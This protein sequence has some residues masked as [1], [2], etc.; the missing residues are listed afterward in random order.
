MNMVIGG[1]GYSCMIENYSEE[2]VDVDDAGV[3]VVFVFVVADLRL[4]TVSST[5]IRSSMKSNASIWILP[6]ATW[7]VDDDALL[8]EAFPVPVPVPDW[9][10]RRTG[11]LVVAGVVWWWKEK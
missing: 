5:S 1:G 8:L 2:D 6:F 4:R 7:V 9:A 10:G 11:L 3:C